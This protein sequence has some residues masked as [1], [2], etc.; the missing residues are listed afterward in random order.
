MQN[1]QLTQENDNI[2]ID[3]WEFAPRDNLLVVKVKPVDETKVKSETGIIIAVQ[4]SN[5]SDRP[6][7]GE[8][9]SKGP[10]VKSIE[11]GNIIYFPGQASYDLGMI[12]TLETGEKFVMVPEDRVDGIRCKDIR[13]GK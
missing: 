13:N 5:V 10:E 9:V 6:F 8:V 7:Y 3:W 1:T 4:P 11:I 2:W 12:K